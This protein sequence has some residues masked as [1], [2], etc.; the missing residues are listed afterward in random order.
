LS[1]RESCLSGGISIISR[2]L[3]DSACSFKSLLL[4]RCVEVIV[5]LRVVVAGAAH[6]LVLVDSSGRRGYVGWRCALDAAFENPFD[7]TRVRRCDGERALA[8][9]VHRG[10]AELVRDAN[11]PE[12]RPKTH[13]EPWI[14]GHSAS[15]T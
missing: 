7:L 1:S 6:A 5:I 12:L 9:S 8:R 4:N 15:R 2:R 14:L 13:F 10:S 11:E 3:F